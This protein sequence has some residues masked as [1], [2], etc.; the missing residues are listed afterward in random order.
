MHYANP[1]PSTSLPAPLACTDVTTVHN[2]WVVNAVHDKSGAPAS[3]ITV[4]VDVVFSKKTLLKSQVRA[5][6][7]C[8]D[9]VNRSMAARGANDVDSTYMIAPM[10]RVWS[11]QV[12]VGVRVRAVC[13]A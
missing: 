11:D 9:H 2:T 5:R 12:R 3:Q 10:I 6:R 1:G 7:W 4:T 8:V 13:C